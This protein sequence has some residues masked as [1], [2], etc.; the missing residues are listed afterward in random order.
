MTFVKVAGLRQTFVKVADCSRN[1]GPQQ[2]E[3]VH[4]FGG[5]AAGIQARNNPK[6]C[7][8]L[9]VTPQH[10]MT[11]HTVCVRIQCRVLALHQGGQKTQESIADSAIVGAPSAASVKNRKIASPGGACSRCV[12]SLFLGTS[13]GDAYRAMHCLLVI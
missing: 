6:R 10:M 8:F 11:K 1:S 13:N 3:A 12:I 2:S 7:M 5:A 4:V 9:G